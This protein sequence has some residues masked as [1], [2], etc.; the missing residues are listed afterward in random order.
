MFGITDGFDVVI[1]NPPY[2]QL[3][4]NS[5]ELSKL[6]RKA[7]FETFS[8][9][10]DIY[11]L[12]YEKGCQL[13]RS[14]KGV[15]VYITSN[16]WLR[17]KYGEKLRAWM[18]KQHTPLKLLE[19]GKNIF[20]NA[21]VDTSILLLRKGA[22]NELCNAVDMDKLDEKN[23]PPLENS[24]AQ[25]RPKGHEPWSILSP[26]EQ[27]IKDK[28]EAKGTPLKEW[29]ITIYR[30]ITTGL[31]DAFIIDNETKVALIAKDP[32]SVEIIKP[33]LRG[34]DIQRYRAK[35]ANLYLIDMHNGYN[36]NQ[37]ININDYPAVKAHLDKYYPKLEKRQDKGKTPYNLRNCAYYAEF[38]KEKLFWMDLTDQGQ[39]AYDNGAIF[40]V[41]TVFTINGQPTKYLCAILNSKIIT[42][43]M[44]N[45][46]QTSGMGVTRWIKVTVERIP[47]PQ[48]SDAQQT[49]L[50]NLMDDILAAK[51]F[52]PPSVDTSVI[53]S[54]IDQLVYELYDLSTKEIEVVEGYLP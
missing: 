2:I 17:A 45:T 27:R 32:R 22:G 37:A 46:A 21:I 49:P 39:F 12:F 13:L 43:F 34:K 24:W 29:D 26:I 42:W 15:L 30:G 53:E 31:N 41:N 10:G 4:N 8:G 54:E 44:R 25:M 33:V 6:Y 23:F 51:K 48:F 20:E 40:C 47:I 50:I 38:A 28:M 9:T 1:G 11:Q 19:M 16:S 3:Q 18:L 5:G 35:Y 36:G 52:D 7:N 14:K